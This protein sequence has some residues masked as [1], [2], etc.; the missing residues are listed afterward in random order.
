MI[1]RNMLE[2]LT[3]KQEEQMII[4]RDKWLNQFFSLPKI[5]KVKARE[6]VEWLYKFCKLKK[7]KVMFV[8][9]PLAMQ[10]LC[11]MLRA[12]VWDNVLAN[13]WDNVRANVRDN[14]RANVWANV[15]DN[16]WANVMDNVRAN[17]WDNV[18]DNVWDNVRANKNLEYFSTSEYCS[19]S[20]YGWVSFYDYFQSIG[21]DLKNENFNEFKELL[22]TGIYDMIQLEGLCVVCGNPEKINRNQ[23]GRLHSEKEPAIKWSDGF[24][25]YYLDGI[26]L[27]KNDWVGITQKIMPAKEAIAFENIEQRTVALK[28]IGYDNVIKE[29]GGKI[30]DTFPRLGY[31]V[32]EIDL[33]DD[34]I[35]ARFVKVKC[36]STGKVTI[37]RIDPRDEKTN[38]CLGAI[39]WTFDIPEEDY[40]LEKE[41]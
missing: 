23:S 2:K 7:P 20:D 6:R 10:Y 39:G 11:N 9:S 5:D 25:L 35:P 30:I 8:E 28:Y 40:I 13:V 29:L 16:V 3:K 24:E 15:R 41:T 18:G 36:P 22:Q 33:K 1:R 19:I 37:L 4:I 27:K 12:N 17:V 32:I 14:V 31:E 34:D 38:K 21:I 26:H